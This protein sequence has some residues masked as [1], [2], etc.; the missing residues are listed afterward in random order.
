AS[1]P[2]FISLTSLDVPCSTST[3]EQAFFFLT[4]LDVRNAA[5]LQCHYH[6]YG[7]AIRALFKVIHPHSMGVILHRHDRQYGTG[8]Y[9]HH[10]RSIGER[11][12]PQLAGC[13]V[14]AGGLLSGL[15]RWL[16]ASTV[17]RPRKVL[18]CDKRSA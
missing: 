4:P 2:F 16:S 8:P 15:R 9:A 7:I 1:Y 10:I 5:S 14:Y 17:G 13:S 12:F 18:K 6:L 11:L 3:Q